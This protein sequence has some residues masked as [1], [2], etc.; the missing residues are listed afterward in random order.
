MSHMAVIWHLFCSNTWTW[1]GAV[2]QQHH[3][4]ISI[5]YT[6]FFPVNPCVHVHIYF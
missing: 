5:L 2:F 1:G 4:F 3:I 6:V